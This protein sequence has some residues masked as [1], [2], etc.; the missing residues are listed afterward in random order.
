MAAKS[1]EEATT[2]LRAPFPASQ[3]GILPRTTKRPE[4]QYVGHG[5]VTARLLDVD[6][7]WTWE[8]L[9]YDSDGKPVLE[10][11][12]QG[13]PVG[14][15]IKLTVNGV[16]RVGFG[17]CEAGQFSAVKVLIGDALRNAAMRFGVALDLWVKGHA[18]DD[19]KF[20]GDTQ[21]G[22]SVVAPPPP[23]L[24]PEEQ[25]HEDHVQAV[26]NQAKDLKMRDNGGTGQYWKGIVDEAGECEGGLLGSAKAI[27]TWVRADVDYA[28]KLL[29][30]M[31]KELKAARNQ[32]PPEVHHEPPP[33]APEKPKRTRAKPGSAVSAEVEEATNVVKGAFPG[34]EE[35]AE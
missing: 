25:A 3:V 32:P 22:P 13:N 15:W 35:V 28:E 17:D 12:A 29:T 4:L 30:N 7:D 31:A 34:T 14:L 19:E 16:T 2:A 20:R 21:G 1:S 9:G 26:L 18:E 23:A 33:P 24:S 11:D 6:P 5:A 27:T 10:R 8:P